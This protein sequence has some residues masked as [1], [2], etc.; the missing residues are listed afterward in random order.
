MHTSMFV[1]PS[2]LFW[3]SA[4]TGHMMADT[5]VQAGRPLQ[6]LLVTGTMAH[7]KMLH[8]QILAPVVRPCL[9]DHSAVEADNTER[10]RRRT[11]MCCFL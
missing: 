1:A 3:Q 7:G 9:S 8:H 6:A 5:Y 4:C 2:V 10:H 11:G